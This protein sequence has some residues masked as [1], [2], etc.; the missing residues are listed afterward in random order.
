MPCAS[1]KKEGLVQ[2]IQGVGTFAAQLHRLATTFT[3]RNIYE[4]IIDRGHIHHAVVHKIEETTA[5]DSFA[6]DLGLPAETV[7]FHTLIVHHD[8]GVPIQSEDR[9]VNPVCAPKYLETDFTKITPSHYLRQV[10]PLWEAKCAITSCLP[11]AREAKLLQINKYE[12]CLV[13]TRQTRRG[14]L[15]ITIARLVHPGSRYSVEGS[16]K[17]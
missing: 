17:P 2:R 6:Q 7:L 12:P 15:P 13:I 5:G 10:A 3:F 1:L 9:Y 16:Y 8:N 4:D 14:N 11:S